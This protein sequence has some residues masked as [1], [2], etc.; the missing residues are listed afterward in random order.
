MYTE[1]KR[2]RSSPCGMNPDFTYCREQMRAAGNSIAPG[3]CQDNLPPDNAR[4]HSFVL[5]RAH[6]GRTSIHLPLFELHPKDQLRSTCQWTRCLNFCKEQLELAALAQRDAG[7]DIQ[8]TRQQ[9]RGPYH[10]TRRNQPFPLN[11][12]HNKCWVRTKESQGV[13][14]V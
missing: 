4:Y 3:L 6:A 2:C 8:R 5:T 14:G 9:C 11:L 10:T 13:R 12:D 7:F 1:Q